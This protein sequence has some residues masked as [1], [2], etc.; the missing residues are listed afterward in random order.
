M[1]GYNLFCTCNVSCQKENIEQPNLM[2]G[3]MDGRNS[4]Y[5]RSCSE[6]KTSIIAKTL[7]FYNRTHFLH[8]WRKLW[9]DLFPTLFW[10]SNLN[11][12]LDFELGTVTTFILFLYFISAQKHWKG[13]AHHYHSAPP[14]QL[15]LRDCLCSK[16]ETKSS[17]PKSPPH[18]A[19][20]LRSC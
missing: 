16:V 12:I 14:T 17:L 4:L 5:W 20:H 13:T 10:E 1:L 19:G 9:V 18:R 3:R 2:H 11:E 7:F 15:F 6:A 8:R